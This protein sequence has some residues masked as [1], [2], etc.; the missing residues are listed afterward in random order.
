VSR[1]V[2]SLC[3]TG[4]VAMSGLASVGMRRI[5]MAGLSAVRRA[6]AAADMASTSGGLTTAMTTSSLWRDSLSYLYHRD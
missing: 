4:C 6:T 3:L 1:S 5:A 2:S